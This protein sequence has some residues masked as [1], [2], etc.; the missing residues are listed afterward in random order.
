MLLNQIRIS[1]DNGVRW[2][3]LPSHLTTLLQANFLASLY[4]IHSFN[5]LKTFFICVYFIYFFF[6]FAIHFPQNGIGFYVY[7]LQFFNYFIFLL[8]F[9]LNIVIV[10]YDYEA[11]VEDELTLRVGDIIKVIDI[12]DDDWWIGE[13]NGRKG[14]FP[15]NFVNKIQSFFLKLLRFF[16]SAFALIF[17]LFKRRSQTSSNSIN[18]YSFVYIINIINIINIIVIY[19]KSKSYI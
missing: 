9:F 14:A 8:F 4:F 7:F 11:E 16:F 1:K 5:V 13:I 6:F 17:S 19:K 3:A 2:F 10:T 12:E 15:S 18:S